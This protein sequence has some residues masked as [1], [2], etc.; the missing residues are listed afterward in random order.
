[1]QLDEE[2]REQ[3]GPVFVP[4]G[5]FSEWFGFEQGQ[6]ITLVG[7]TGSGKTTLARTLL[8]PQREFV[9]VLATKME[10]DSLYEPLLAQGYQITESFNPNPQGD[11]PTRVIFRPPLWEPT[12]DALD[13]QSEAFRKCLVQIYQHGRWAIY[14]DEERYL[15]ETLGLRAQFNV[16]YLQGRSQKTSIIGATQ[17]P[18]SIP[19][20]AFDQ[21]DYLFLWRNTD[22]YNVQRM[23]EFA[24][25]DVAMV[26]TIIP[27]L[28][29]HEFLFIDTRTG[30]MAR[31]KVVL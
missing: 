31:S 18:V 13:E 23:A 5:Q 17:R 27:R 25:A 8:L 12:K 19:L 22:R 16:L 9:C 29:H 4:W 6:H 2:A 21:A 15:T 24:G 26:R 10:D 28:P 14:A 1:M 3:G 20:E 11:E 30:Y 7:T